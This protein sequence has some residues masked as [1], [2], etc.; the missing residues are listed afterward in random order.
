M[1]PPPPPPPPQKN[2]CTIYFLF[3]LPAVHLHLGSKIDVSIPIVTMASGEYPCY[4]GARIF[5]FA[6]KFSWKRNSY[7]HF[8]K[9]AMFIY[10]A[11]LY[12]GAFAMEMSTD[13]PIFISSVCPLIKTLEMLIRFLLKLILTKFI[14]AFLSALKSIITVISHKGLQQSVIKCDSLNEYSCEKKKLK[15]R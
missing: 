14:D 3:V 11:W 10:A 5:L 9:T 13:A 7:R 12:V 8:I 4:S 1:R 2:Q 15:K 6:T